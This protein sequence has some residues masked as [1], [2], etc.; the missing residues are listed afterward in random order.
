MELKNLDEIKINEIAE[1]KLKCKKIMNN[2]KS[3]TAFMDAKKRLD[4]LNKMEKEYYYFKNE[5]AK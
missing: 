3:Y 5:I 2:A 4:K 1:E